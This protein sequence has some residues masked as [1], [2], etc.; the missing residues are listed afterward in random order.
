MTAPVKLTLHWY[1]YDEL[2][3]HV[4]TIDERSVVAAKWANWSTWLRDALSPILPSAYKGKKLSVLSGCIKDRLEDWAMVA[5]CSYMRPTETLYVRLTFAVD[6][7]AHPDYTYVTDGEALQHLELQLEPA[8][9]I[10]SRYLKAN[11]SVP[12]IMCILELAKP[13]EGLSPD[14]AELFSRQHVYNPTT[15]NH[16]R[17]GMPFAVSVFLTYAP[18]DF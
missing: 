3:A 4:H 8:F 12:R 6:N 16:I 5:K 18:F 14:H 15:G 10:L 17:T 7:V 9:A 13:I 2:V 11:E 1:T